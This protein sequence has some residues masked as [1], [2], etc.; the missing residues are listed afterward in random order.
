MPAPM[1]APTPSAT[2]LSADSER[3]GNRAPSCPS[4]ASLVSSSV[5]FFA[6]RLVK[7]G[8][9]QSKGPHDNAANPTWFTASHQSRPAAC[10]LDRAVAFL[11]LVISQQFPC[12]G[13]MDHGALIQHIGA[14]GN[15]ERQF[16]ILL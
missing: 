4:A 9:P 1:I 7:G 15:I 2:R 13:L 16:D 10:L 8:N 12:R 6:H 3:L 11:D 5:D 14:V